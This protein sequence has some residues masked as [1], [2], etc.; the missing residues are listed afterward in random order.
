MG[1]LLYIMKRQK[2]YR[3]MNRELL[4]FVRKNHNY[5]SPPAQNWL[6]GDYRLYIPSNGM[7]RVYNT[8]KKRWG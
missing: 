7:Q 8:R 4:R 3:R 5:S 6:E 1:L 2:E